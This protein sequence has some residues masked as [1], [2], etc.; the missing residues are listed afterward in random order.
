MVDHAE[1]LRVQS[2]GGWLAFGA[3]AFWEGSVGSAW[4]RG[5][6]VQGEGREGWVVVCRGW[7]SASQQLA[8]V[9]MVGEML[10]LVLGVVLGVIRLRSASVSYSGLTSIGMQ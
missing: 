10:D 8:K 2:K 6:D 5:E 9:R 4:T 7:W 3:D 1:G